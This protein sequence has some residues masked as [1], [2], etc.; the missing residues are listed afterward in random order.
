MGGQAGSPA[1]ADGAAGEHAETVALVT[2][3]SSGIGRAAAEFLAARGAS[4]VVCSAGPGEARAVAGAMA[5]R[6]LAAVPA[7]AD[8]RDQDSVATAVRIAVD[9]FGGLDTL[10]TSAGIQAYGTVTDTDEQTWDNVFAVNVKGVFLAARA[11]LPQLRRSRRGA[12][13]IVSSVQATVTRP[14]W[15]PTRRARGR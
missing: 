4:V 2:G 12:I 5:G 3:A 11:A 7:I 10:V 15:R 1:V 6:G 14:A 9:A 13:V 8:V